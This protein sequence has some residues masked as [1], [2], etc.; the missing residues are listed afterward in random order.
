[1]VPHVTVE[2]LFPVRN[3]VLSYGDG[4]LW[5]PGAAAAAGN[6]HSGDEGTNPAR[7]ALYRTEEEITMTVDRLVCANCSG[8]VSEGRCP[9]CRANRAR[10]QQENP[11][12][13]I[14]P[15]ALT[16]LLIALLTVALVVEHATA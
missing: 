1:M 8:P 6:W 2:E 15:V 12:A 14:S 7:G 10:L 11:W 5:Q 13:S 16:A 3:R 4:D 9:V